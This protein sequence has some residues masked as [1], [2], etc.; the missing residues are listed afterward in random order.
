MIGS[1]SEDA[2]MEKRV[3]AANIEKKYFDSILISADWAAI[4]YRYVNTDKETGERTPWDG[5]EFYRFEK[6]GDELKIAEAWTK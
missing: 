1:V 3:S 6:D 4:H 2:A 5:M